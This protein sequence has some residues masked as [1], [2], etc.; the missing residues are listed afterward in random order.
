MKPELL[1]LAGAATGG[2]AAALVVIAGMEAYLRATIPASSGG[3]IY[4]Y[5][6][7][8][9]RYKV[10]KPDAS[11]VAWGK[12]LRTNEL[13]FRD[14]TRSVPAKQPGEFRIVVLGS[15]FTVSAG[16]DYEDIYT[17][18]LQQHLRQVHPGVR[19]M[20]LAVGGYNPVQYSLVLEEVGL[21]LQPDMVLIALFPD[22]DFRMDIYD[23]NRRVAEGSAPPAR[24]TPWY[25]EAYT[26]RA[27]G[28]RI[29]DKVVSVV[30]KP[31]ASR[32]DPAQA[33]RGWDENIAAL[34]RIARISRE[35]GL[36]LNVAVLPH[37]FNFEKQRSEFT[38]IERMCREQGLSCLNLL[39]P[40]IAA[41][42]PEPTL[43]LNA[44]D[45]HP[46]ERYN[47][48]V[49]ELLA[50]HLRAALPV[51]SQNWASA[52]TVRRTDFHKP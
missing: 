19:V 23:E 22:S 16:V 1:R 14:S 6:L 35:H 44:L 11:V 51:P 12:E 45:S 43:R 21:A 29:V 4:E 26:Y 27:Y 2:L 3:S 8:T 50:A 7:A 46:N 48:L 33:R 24:P 41:R 17:S 34:Q 52:P 13:G 47:A 40:F 5:T 31:A 32:S 38:R 30:R 9:Q 42:V 20:N 28:S 49:A 18:R 25:E 10:M 37:T 39:E 36:A 15:S